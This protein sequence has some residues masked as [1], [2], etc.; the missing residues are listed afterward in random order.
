LYPLAVVV[1]VIP[2]LKILFNCFC[3]LY[4]WNYLVKKCIIQYNSDMR[5]LDLN[6]VKPL[7]SRALEEDLDSDGDVTSLAI[8]DHSQDG[9]F[10]LYAKQSGILC[11]SG[12]FTLV[13]SEVDPKINVL[14]NFQDGDKLSKGAVVAEVNGPVLTVLQAER[15]AL[16]FIS[17]LSGIATKTAM[18]AHA[19]MGR[20]TIL[21]TRKTLPGYRNLQKYAV[22]CGGGKNHRTGLYDMVMIKDN[23]IDAAGS[24]TSAVSKVRTR[25]D[26]RF[27]IE[28]ETRNLDEVKEALACGVDR[29]MLDNMDNS[30]MKDAVSIINGGTEIEVSGNMTYERIPEIASLGGIDF[31]SFGELTHTI[32][33]FDFSLKMHRD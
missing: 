11:G 25:W 27:A 30:M 7:V 5:K 17:H 26:K 8:F 29:I 9:S 3:G 32:T 23:H 15:T 14:F 1:I 12:V 28:V 24:I 18:F 21:D 22:R 16:N 31:I 6:D 33:V 4:R 20:V 13:C 10:T 2:Y 19:S